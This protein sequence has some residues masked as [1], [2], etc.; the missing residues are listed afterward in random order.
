MVVIR[1][2]RGGAKAARFSILL[3]LTSVPAATVASLSALASI[4]QAQRPMK[5]VSVLRK[6]A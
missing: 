6:I 2:A 5:K 3:W 4:T 1:L